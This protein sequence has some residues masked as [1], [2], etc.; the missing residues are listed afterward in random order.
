MSEAELI[1]VVIVE[2]KRRAKPDL[3]TYNIDLSQSSG[4]ERSVGTP[5]LAGAQMPHPCRMQFLTHES[6][7]PCK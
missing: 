7:S 5:Q 1:N 4:L 6:C 3:I 2:D